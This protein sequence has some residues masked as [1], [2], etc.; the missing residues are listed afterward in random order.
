MT[1]KVMA[2]AQGAEVDFDDDWYDPIPIEAADAQEIYAIP[3]GLG[4]SS[5]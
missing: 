1:M 3:F 5:E 2:A 4:Y